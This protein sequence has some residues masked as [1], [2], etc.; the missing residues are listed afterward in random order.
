M[1]VLDLYM[2][3]YSSQHIHQYLFSTISVSISRYRTTPQSSLCTTY[4]QVTR[5]CTSIYVLQTMKGD[6]RSCLRP[7][8][9]IIVAGQIFKAH[10]RHCLNSVSMR[11]VLDSATKIRPI[12][13]RSWAL[14]P[15]C[16]PGTLSDR[17]V[18]RT[19]YERHLNV[20]YIMHRAMVLLR[21]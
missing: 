4:F 8:D 1:I 18:R 20:S 21:L 10:A 17:P 19:C 2:F 11:A 15:I 12:S 9:S 3:I 13:R 16:A 6:F 5:S 14:G 7:A